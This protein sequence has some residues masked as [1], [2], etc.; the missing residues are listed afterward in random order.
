[1]GGVSTS[2]VDPLAGLS[3]LAL[4]FRLD[5]AARLGKAGMGIESGLLGIA[6]ERG[7]TNFPD[8]VASDS[9]GMSMRQVISMYE[10]YCNEK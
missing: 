5:P 10:L 3:S 9:D 8:A 6:G 4:F 7:G 2:R 1:M